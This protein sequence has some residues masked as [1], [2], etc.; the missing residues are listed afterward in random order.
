MINKLK[1]YAGPN[2]PHAAQQPQVLDIAHAR[3]STVMT[4]PLTQTTGR[5][6]E[7]VARVRLRPGHRHDHRQQADARGLLPDRAR[8]R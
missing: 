2:H 5:R 8:T 7:A 3:R 4:K 6:K 1:V